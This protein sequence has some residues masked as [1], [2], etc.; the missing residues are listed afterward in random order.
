MTKKVPNGLQLDD[1]APRYGLKRIERREWW[2]W[3]TTVVV[4]LLLTAA[5]VSFL[6]PLLHSGETWEITV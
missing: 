2:L 1:Q 3:G 4:T 6:P 5:V